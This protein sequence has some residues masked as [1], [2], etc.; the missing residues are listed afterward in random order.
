MINSVTVTNPKGESVLIELMYPE[1]SGFAVKEIDGLGPPDA[2]VNITELSTMDG[3]YFNTA[4]VGSR[5]LVFNFRFVHDY[6]IEEARML[7]YKYFP[8]KKRIKIVIQ[9]ETRHVETYG[10]V[11][12]NQPDIFTN[13][14]SAQ[15]SVL[16]PDAYFYST[17]DEGLIVSNFYSVAPQFEFPFYNKHLVDP[18]IN[19]GEIRYSSIQNV[20]YEGDVDAGVIIRVHATGTATGLSLYRTDSMEK[21]VIDHAKFR[22][23]TGGTDIIAGDDIIISTVRG[24]KYAYLLR[25]GALTSIINALGVDTNWF[26]LSPG[27]NQIAFDA[28]TGKLNLQITVEHRILYEGV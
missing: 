13:E 28:T 12:K 3:G 2:D 14:T 10:Y 26:Q 21:I 15:I 22:A 17:G 16:C 24:D 7:S 27:D 6:S 23:I 20:Y 8:I 1:R 18:T 9:T 5:N 4:R 25:N 11:E 19:M